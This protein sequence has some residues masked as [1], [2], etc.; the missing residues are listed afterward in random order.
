MTVVA[1]A[2]AGTLIG[3]FA[4]RRRGGPP[5]H[6]AQYAASYGVVFAIVGLFVS[7]FLLRI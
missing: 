2:L 5:L 1:F 6:M 7:V 4:A 3:V